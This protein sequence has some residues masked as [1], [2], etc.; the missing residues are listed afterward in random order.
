MRNLFG[1]LHEV[2]LRQLLHDELQEHTDH[3]QR[4]VLQEILF[5]LDKPFL[6]IRNL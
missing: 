2:E 5:I 3:L 6:V 4:T 1:C